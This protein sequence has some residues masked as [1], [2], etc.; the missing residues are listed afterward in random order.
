LHSNNHNFLKCQRDDDFMSAT[1]SRS[2]P[3]SC[4]HELNGIIA[5]ELRE[6]EHDENGIKNNN[7][8]ENFY[9]LEFIL[10]SFL[11]L[12]GRFCDFLNF[13]L[14]FVFF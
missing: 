8:R 2:A 11:D 5:P 14:N 3:L 10:S 12:D 1:R 9:M 6:K 7:K 4:L 13:Y